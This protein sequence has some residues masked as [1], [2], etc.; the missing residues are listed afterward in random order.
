MRPSGLAEV[1]ESQT[2]SVDD[3]LISQLHVLQTTKISAGPGN[4]AR[5]WYKCSGPSGLATL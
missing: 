4:E 5:V 2:G 3:I 1:D